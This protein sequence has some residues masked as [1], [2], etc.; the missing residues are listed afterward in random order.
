MKKK[1]DIENTFGKLDQI[2]L[3]KIVALVADL[4]NIKT[5]TNLTEEGLRKLENCSLE[6]ESLKKSYYW[7]LF[8]LLKQ[9]HMLD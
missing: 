3:E 6:L 8:R 4:E 5:N 7:R 2:D 1:E 9:G